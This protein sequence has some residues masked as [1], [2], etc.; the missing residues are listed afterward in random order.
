VSNFPHW[1]NVV[2]S[3]TGLALS[4]L[5][6]AN[7]ASRRIP[8]NAVTRWEYTHPR[9]ANFLRFNRAIGPDVDKGL[10]ALGYMLRGTAW[11]TVVAR[12]IVASA[13]DTR[14][15]RPE[16]SSGGENL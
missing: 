16:A 8:A 11:P 3:W 1:L 9:I 6:L 13:A 12:T 14:P 5:A 7:I 15:A 4:L 2:L 10:R